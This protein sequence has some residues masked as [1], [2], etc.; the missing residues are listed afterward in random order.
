MKSLADR[1]VDLAEWVREASSWEEWEEV[2]EKEQESQRSVQEERWLW[3]RLEESDREQAKAERYNNL[4]KSRTIAKA[5]EKMK[6]G[7]EQPG[8]M[9]KLRRVASEGRVQG[10][11]AKEPGVRCQGDGDV[12]LGRSQV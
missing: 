9:D 5:R 12:Q 3:R 1:A 10:G 4:K 11:A 2:K 7:K 8:I 6:V